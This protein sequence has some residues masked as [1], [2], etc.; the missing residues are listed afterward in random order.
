M[1]RIAVITDIHNGHDAAPKMGTAAPR[2]LREFTD[3][4]NAQDVDA[5]FEL[6]DRVNHLDHD[7]DMQSMREVAA[8]FQSIHPPCYHILGNHDVDFLSI[9]D[10]ERIMDCAFETQTVHVDGVDFVLWN[11]NTK[12][13]NEKRFILTD[14]N[15]DDLEDALSDSSHPTVVCSHFPLDNSRTEGHYYFDK[16]PHR[17]HYPDAQ[18]KRVRDIINQSQNVILCM[19]GHA[20][21][22]AYT[23][24]NGVH[25]VTLPS[26]TETFTTHPKPNAAWSIIDIKKN[27]IL[28]EVFGE[29]PMKYTLEIKNKK[30]NWLKQN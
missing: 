13:N 9:E 27:G 30:H 12:D 25:Y 24:I 6:G 22:N 28:I 16:N 7:T 23:C 20:H 18:I 8:Y 14:Q 29:T 3:F 2:L 5:V 21:W 11:A 17:A 1:A 26:L 10:N 4:V 19:N 15:V